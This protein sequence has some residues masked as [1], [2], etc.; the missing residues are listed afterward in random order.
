M[1]HSPRPGHA[2]TRGN[3]LIRSAAIAA[4]GLFCALGATLVA[5][6]EAATRGPDITLIE[7][8]DRTVYEYRQSGHLRMVKIVPRFGKPYY[9][10]PLD[11]TDGFGDLDQAGMLLPQWRIVEF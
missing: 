7:G 9:L 1:L 5:A 3:A 4:A 2:I 11:P 6:Q 10:V 8:E